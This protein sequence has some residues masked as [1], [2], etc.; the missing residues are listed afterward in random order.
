MSLQSDLERKP[1]EAM[2][3]S[4]KLEASTWTPS[5]RSIR[6]NIQPTRGMFD[7]DRPN[8]GRLIDHK[9]MLDG[10]PF[11]ASEKLA[12]GLAAYLTSPSR[13]WWR[14]TLSDP[15][16]MEYEPVKLWLGEAEREMYA[17]QAGSNIHTS[18][19]EA[20]AEYGSFGTSAM[21]LLQDR[22][23]VIR[24]RTYTI[25][26]YYLAQGAD[27][28][29]NRAAYHLKKT[30]GQLVE[31]YGEDAVSPTVKRLYDQKR[32]DSWVTCCHIIVPNLNRKR[33]MADNRNM[34]FLSLTWE[35]GSP[36]D[37]Y[38]DRSGF[39]EFPILAARWG[40]TGNNVYGNSAPGWTT[41]GDAKMLQKLKRDELMGVEK[42]MD[43]PVQSDATVDGSVNTL[44]GGLTRTS[45]TT[46]DGGVRPA[47]QIQPEFRAIRDVINDTRMAIREGHFIDLF[48]MISGDEKAGRTAREIVERASERMTLLGPLVERLYQEKL[49]PFI[50]RQFNVMYRAGMLPPPPPELEGRAINIELI[51]IL[52]QAQK[53]TGTRQ[54][55]E[56]LAVVGEMAQ[57]YPEAKDLIDP[58]EAIRA[59]H[60]MI[61]APPKMLRSPEAVAKLREARA[62]QQAQQAQQEALERTA[63]LAKTASE[64]KVGDGS[65]LDAL[66]GGQ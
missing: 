27:H 52:A 22:E 32:L 61:G 15:D 2:I 35:E 20:Y 64:T 55:D 5:W 7:G 65:A 1:Y 53:A 37:T 18:F 43:P 12:D 49:S 44:P 13:P 10:T 17:V 33:S 26:E 50:R 47:Y 59:R 56:Q 36:K 30:V 42:V 38:L 62:Q 9:I 51:S 46:R 28:R 58:D 8:N 39:M 16:L 14:P 31:E 11:R 40:V 41:L 48:Q 3:A 21:A 6:D 63:A 29:V 60:S 23:D 57:V 34:P 54:I 45:S 24:G 19:R 66:A 4:M 25:G